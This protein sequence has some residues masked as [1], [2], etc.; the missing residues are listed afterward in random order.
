VILLALGAGASVVYLLQAVVAVRLLEAVNYFEHYGLSRTSRRVRPIDSWDTDS[1]FTLYTLVGLSR[2]ADHHANASRPYHQLRHFDE[3]PK[4]P[5]GYFATV[6][7]LIFAN[8]SF[9]AS[10]G[11]ELERRKLG[12]FAPREDSP[13]LA[14]E[15]AMRAAI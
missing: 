7:W 3:S 8:R 4:L 5:Y 15:P 1:W 10:M 2:H 9:R 11:A 6:T 14:V 13:G 12:P